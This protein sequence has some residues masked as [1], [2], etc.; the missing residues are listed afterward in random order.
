MVLFRPFQSH[1]VSNG[2]IQ[3]MS[4]K[5]LDVAHINLR[6]R[7]SLRKKLADEAEKHRFSLNNEI[8]VRLEASFERQGFQSLTES[9]AL[10]IA[11]QKLFTEA[12]ADLAQRLHSLDKQGDLLRASEALV[13]A[14]EQGKQRGIKDAVARVKQIKDAIDEAAAATVRSL[15]TT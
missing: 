1:H 8:R 4:R 12:T 14:T 13:L 10:L 3:V 7:E 2:A 5:P 6:I 15:P 9:G 11:A